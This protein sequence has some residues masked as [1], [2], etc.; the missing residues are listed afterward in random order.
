M[1]YKVGDKVKV[2]SF[3]DAKKNCIKK[4]HITKVGNHSIVGLSN[5]YIEELHN[6]EYVTIDRI[7]LLYDKT[8]Q[9]HLEHY[10]CY[11]IP[12]MVLQAGEQ[13]EFDFE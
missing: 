4:G 10:D 11:I 8:I 1:T 6:K 3:K 13:L 5:T 7:F 9:L 12:E 2:M